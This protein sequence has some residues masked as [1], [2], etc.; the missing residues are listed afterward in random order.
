MRFVYLLA[1][2]L[3]IGIGPA[4]AATL[5]WEEIT[6]SSQFMNPFEPTN[7]TCV[8]WGDASNVQAI[9]S[10]PNVY[11]APGNE[12][13]QVILDGLD[14]TKTWHCTVRKGQANPSPIGQYWTIYK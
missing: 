7:P 10:S 13:A 2:G 14:K 9:G 1:T 8:M 11:Y 4:R 6:I 3:L 12:K 5:P